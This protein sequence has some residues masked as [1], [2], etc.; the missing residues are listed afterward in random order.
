MIWYVVL[1]VIFAAEIA[2]IAYWQLRTERRAEES[3]KK[4]RIKP[5]VLLAAAVVWVIFTIYDRENA[6]IVLLH[7]LVFLFVGMC[8]DGVLSLIRKKKG[9]GS[10]CVWVAA[11]AACLIWLSVGWAAAHHVR[12]TDY[13]LTSTKAIGQERLRI[14][15]IS[16]TH[17]GTTMDGAGFAKKLK[18]ISEA[19]PD[20]VVV[21]GDFTDANTSRED[22]VRSCEELGK[23]KTKYGI[24]FVFGNHD[25]EDEGE[26]NFTSAELKSELEKNGV[27]VLRDE[28][29]RISDNVYLIGRRDASERRENM[30]TLAAGVSPADYLIVLDHQPNHFSEEAA[31]GAD[32][33]LT[34]HTH[35]GQLMP[36]PLVSKLLPSFFGDVDFMYGMRMYGSTACIVSSGMSSWEFR[37]KTGAV[38]E[39]VIIDVEGQ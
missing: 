36:I 9:K 13:S 7:L 21:T 38:S 26:R 34:G 30:K 35:G 37:F 23:L 17:I 33:V 11:S 10:A 32:L 20:L 6:I 39:F 8:G 27:I 29:V 15:Q 24:C 31:A 18:G 25:C 3:G 4:R 2:G 1:A 19:K 14:A 22:M 12:R 5:A 16:D 28:G